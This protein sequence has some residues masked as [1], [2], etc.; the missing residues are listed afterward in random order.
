M[1]VT[2]K[3]ALSGAL[4]SVIVA[5][6]FIISGVL[7]EVKFKIDVD[8]NTFY[9]DGKIIAVEDWLL[10]SQRTFFTL[11][12]QPDGV[13]CSRTTAT[14]CYVDDYWQRIDRV[15]SKKLLY[16][17]N[18]TDVVNVKRATKY[19]DGLWRNDTMRFIE[20]TNIDEFP[21]HQK[22]E[23]IPKNLNTNYRAIW[24]I[25][26]LNTTDYAEGYYLNDSQKL[27]RLIFE[28]AVVD[29]CN[30][31]YKM[32]YAELNKSKGELLIHFDNFTGIHELNVRLY[33]P[34][35]IEFVRELELLGLKDIEGNNFTS[36]D[37]KQ[38]FRTDLL[39]LLS[40]TNN[41]WQDCETVYKIANPTDYNL[42][43]ADNGLDLEYFQFKG[44]LDVKNS[45][46]FILKNLTRDVHQYVYDYENYTV[47]EVS[48][49]TGKLESYNKTRLKSETL[50]I[51]E[52]TYEALVPLSDEDVI[53]AHDE[54]KLVVRGSIDLLEGA[55]NVVNYAG[56]RYSEYAEW[57][58]NADRV[59]SVN[60]SV[61][62]AVSSN[63]TTAIINLDMSN[64]TIFNSS[65]RIYV[66][67]NNSAGNLTQRHSELSGY[68]TSTGK[69]YF[70]ID[71]DIAN[72]TD[73]LE[74]WSVV[75][76]QLGQPL[77]TWKHIFFDG[78][79]LTGAEGY[80]NIS[81]NDS[82]FQQYKVGDGS[83]YADWRNK[84]AAP[85]G[86][87][88]EQVSRDNMQLDG[89][90]FH[91]VKTFT[92]DTKR[93]D[94]EVGFLMTSNQFSAGAGASIWGLANGTG[95]VSDINNICR[96]Q[97]VATDGIFFTNSIT[98][99]ANRTVR[100]YTNASA[101]DGTEIMTGANKISKGDRHYYIIN[102]TNQTG[103]EA[104]TVDI[105]AKNT[106]GSGFNGTIQNISTTNMPQGKTLKLF[107][108]TWGDEDPDLNTSIGA[109]T[110][111]VFPQNRTTAYVGG[112]S[113]LNPPAPA[114]TTSPSAI[115]Q[116][117]PANAVINT[118]NSFTFFGNATDDIVLGNA[119][120]YSNESG[121]F[122]ANKTTTIGG[123][124]ANISLNVSSYN[125]TGLTW[126]FRVC[127][128][129]NNCN[130]SLNR[131]L[132]VNSFPS[133]VN[134]TNPANGTSNGT[135]TH[136]FFT[137]A[138]DIR[139]LF[140]ATLYHNIDGSWL[141]NQT[142]TKNGTTN[143]SSFTVTSIIPGT[144]LWN[145]QWCDTE[146]NCSQST[147]NATFTVTN[148][149]PN[150]TRLDI[151]STD[152]GKNNSVQNLTVY[153]RNL[154]DSDGDF[155]KN[156]TTW[157][158]NGSSRNLL[159]MPFEGGSNSTFTRDYS[160]TNNSGIKNGTV[161]G[162]FYNVTGGVDGKRAYTFNGSQKVYINISTRLIRGT[163]FSTYGAWI[164]PS[165][166]ACSGNFCM[167]LVQ[168][169]NLADGIEVYVNDTGAPMCYDG[170]GLTISNYTMSINRWY[171][172]MCRN[173]KTSLTMFINGVEITSDTAISDDGGLDDSLGRLG[174]D[175]IIGSHPSFSNSSSFYTFNGNIDDVQVYN[176]SLSKEQILALYQN[177]TDII[178]GPELN[179]LENWSACT[180]PNDVD[181]GS[182]GPTVC[183]ENVSILNAAPDVTLN[184]PLNYTRNGSTSQKFNA[185]MSD[186]DLDEL[187]NATLYHNISGSWLANQTIV[188]NGTSNSTNFTVAN[189]PLGMYAW[190]V[191]V[192]DNYNFCNQNDINF[193]F[194]R[195]TIVIFPITVPITPNNFTIFEPNN[196]SFLIEFT[197]STQVN[198][199]WY[200]NGSA[201][202]VSRVTNGSNTS[203]FTF[204]NSYTDAGQ[205]NIS[206]NFTGV[207]EN[208]GMQWYI[209]N[210]DSGSGPVNATFYYGANISNVTGPVFKINFSNLS[211]FNFSSTSNITYTQFNVTPINRSLD[212]SEGPCFSFANNGT[213]T[214]MIQ[215]SINRTVPGTLQFKVGTTSNITLSK[216]INS[217]VINLSSFTPNEIIDVYCWASFIGRNISEKFIFNY[218][219][220][221]T[222]A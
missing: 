69:V 101:T 103:T 183:S 207:L 68:G 62:S 63:V 210:N 2:T 194:E 139:Q 141:A 47:S 39:D 7:T 214:K 104:V 96:N 75:V 46:I 197:N 41:C 215:L 12:S 32:S 67:R 78:S 81:G 84:T 199:T 198:I 44:E 135:R 189:I 49:I 80:T 59:Y 27:C 116:I 1:K 99:Q 107:F 172:F 19:S 66:A 144:Y 77:R 10:E 71:I 57:Y 36:T 98:G 180:T 185:N 120:L 70:L 30:A 110:L 213:A 40:N 64:T 174:T 154:T 88:I 26:N 193:T 168:S 149:A 130:N 35:K 145:V 5:S 138:T 90:C 131:T 9:K 159:N 196:K 94:Y 85:I 202:N 126:F 148:N 208:V 206:V 166:F 28:Y 33:D 219:E 93:Y 186:G 3:Y 134:L 23:F 92:L 184:N 152:P 222:D 143:T 14:R 82:I 114:D 128:N 218:T 86:T 4:I 29:W 195:R 45:K 175:F 118:S 105:R 177:K 173:N 181:G 140:N 216:E 111:M 34:D 171:H 156:I 73:I 190:N 179:Y 121:S 83:E 15:S 117:N 20:T 91:S 158:V 123:T 109:I 153:P 115:N 51:K 38:Y 13:I 162:A 48:N 217:T 212:F 169:S 97:N 124:F 87:V 136:L 167:V 157:F 122:V 58:A 192:C 125:D 160:G 17:W 113:A 165:T 112:G 161:L 60:L 102:I 203:N 16:T 89:S 108:K 191:Q 205:Y 18:E 170:N 132:T 22:I 74:N 187:V 147:A 24:R 54:T 201:V 127:D 31:R 61:G 50:Q 150:L 164:R 163:N 151:N 100:V 95:T 211:A 106:N 43:L 200:I 176:Y 155:V 221:I 188:L 25:K 8:K 209:V 21:E 55:D 137:N 204:V 133:G 76:G 72:N 11:G 6:I 178:V 56:I 129:V 52:E 119:T 182:D 79:N 220:N 42:S 146:G 65:A 142:A 53:Q 37:T